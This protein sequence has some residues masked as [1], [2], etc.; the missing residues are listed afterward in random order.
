MMKILVVD[1]QGGGIGGQLVAAIK[2]N[3]TECSITAVGTNAMATSVM[4]KAGATYAATGENAIVIGCRKTDV[5]VGPIGIVLAD[6]M[7]GEVTSAMALAVGQSSA[8]RILV[9]TNHC[10]TLVAGVA[11]VSIG[12]L[13]QS[14]VKKLLTLQSGDESRD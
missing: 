2:E 3:V 14:V 9:P 12:K 13:I 10:G 1:R 5:I 6:S 8:T 7:R 4:I 11:D